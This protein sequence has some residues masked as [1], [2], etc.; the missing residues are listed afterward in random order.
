M[1]E[2]I[3]FKLRKEDLSAF[4]RLY[5]DM[6]AKDPGCSGFLSFEALAASIKNAA[7]DI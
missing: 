6:T 7:V 4:L 1:I 2:F 5:S 3:I